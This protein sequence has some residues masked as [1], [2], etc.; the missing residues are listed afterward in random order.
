MCSSNQQ[1]KPEPIEFD[2]KLGIA[3][4]KLLEI[5]ERHKRYRHNSLVR[6]IKCLGHRCA[7]RHVSPMLN[8]AIGMLGA[9]IIMALCGST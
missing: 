4:E 2:K 5:G 3:R 6:K 9:Q 8:A 7:V 1:D